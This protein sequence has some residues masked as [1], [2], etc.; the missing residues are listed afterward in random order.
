MA[1]PYINKDSESGDDH[2]DDGNAEDGPSVRCCCGNVC[3]RGVVEF[4][5]IDIAERNGVI[6]HQIEDFKHHVAVRAGFFIFGGKEVGGA[7]CN[8]VTDLIAV[9]FP[10]DTGNAEHGCRTLLDRAVSVGRGCGVIGLEKR[11]RG[12]GSIDAGDHV[13][14]IGNDNLLGGRK[15]GVG[16]ICRGITEDLGKDLCFHALRGGGGE[17]VGLCVVGKEL[18]CTGAGDRVN[19]IGNGGAE[20]ETPFGK[21]TFKR[22]ERRDGRVFHNDHIAVV[23][24]EEG[25]ELLDL[26]EISGRGKVI[27]GAVDDDDI[28]GTV[29]AFEIFNGEVDLLN[30]EACELKDLTPFGCFRESRLAVALE[31]VCGGLFHLT[32]E[33]RYCRE[34]S[35]FCVITDELSVFSVGSE[36]GCRGVFLCG[37]TEDR[38]AVFIA[39]LEDDVVERGRIKRGGLVFFRKLGV[40]GRIV[41]NEVDVIK[42]RHELLECAIDI[43]RIG[44]VIAEIIFLTHQNDVHINGRAAFGIQKVVELLREGVGKRE[45]ACRCHIGVP[46]VY[47]GK[48][49]HNDIEYDNEHDEDD[50]NR[51]G[52]RAVFQ[53]SLIL[54][55]FRCRILCFVQICHVKYPPKS[56]FGPAAFFEHTDR[57][58]Q[59]NGGNR[60]EIDERVIHEDAA[61]KIRITAGYGKTGK[62]IAD[63]FVVDVG[64][65]RAY[66][67]QENDRTDGAECRDELVFRK[68][69]DEDADGDKGAADEEYA[70]NTAC[71]ASGV[72]R[73]VHCERDIID[74]RG[75][76]EGSAEHRERGEIFTEN[77]T[78]EGNGCGRDELVGAHLAFFADELH[79]EQGNDDDEKIEQDDEIIG[80]I[81]IFAGLDVIEHEKECTDGKKDRA[82]HIADGRCE[83]GAHFALVDCEH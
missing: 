1:S 26:G 25:A 78:C 4:F 60:D 7:E 20:A 77:D 72:G 73:A 57:E 68:G 30:V 54:R 47:R 64:I 11:E 56:G 31:I 80:V 81:C 39:K 33:K 15:Y 67:K 35:L 17:N 52:K 5:V 43:G 3:K 65:E 37:N 62:E 69:R 13:R 59:K 70:D 32:G 36:E 71:I 41:S 83:I 23:G 24:S 44:A 16:E 53:V 10:D 19:G 45:E 55:R 42:R 50:R 48:R 38:I 18:T 6:P 12:F 21:K 61:C 9:H 74:D 2:G 29:F 40:D 34:D 14:F 28:I 27:F 63:H 79:G 76:D 51:N 46:T 22:G 66:E 49:G 82:E 8:N 75:Y 58:E